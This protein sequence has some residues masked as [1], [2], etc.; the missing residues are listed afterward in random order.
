VS[1]FKVADIMVKT[2]ADRTLRAIPR[3][4]F[5]GFESLGGG[6]FYQSRQ[7]PAVK[8]SAA[9]NPCAGRMGWGPAVTKL[10]G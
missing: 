10:Q 1:V 6:T 3:R 9:E 7:A 5:T 2:R 4:G 8:A